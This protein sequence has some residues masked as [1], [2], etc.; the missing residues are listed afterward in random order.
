MP[1]LKKSVR[2]IALLL[3]LAVALSFSATA[4]EL[5]TFP[6]GVGHWAE[7]YLRRAVAE[8]LLAGDERGMLAPDD[9]ATM[10]QTLTILC[11]LLWP[12]AQVAPEDEGVPAGKWY[13]GYAAAARAM[14]IDFGNDELESTGFP[15]AR[16][17]NILAQAFRLIP[18]EPDYTVLDVFSDAGTL[19]DEDRPAAAALVAAG[20][21][22]GSDGRLEPYS[23]VSRAELVTMILRIAEATLDAPAETLPGAAVLL[24]AKG[25]SGKTLNKTVWLACGAGETDLRGVKAGT[26][27]VLSR[28]AAVLTDYNTDIDRLVLAGGAGDSLTLEGGHVGTLVIAPGAP[29]SVTVR[30]ADRVELTADGR[31]VTAVSAKALVISGKGNTVTATGGANAALTLTDRA[32]NNRV[33]AQAYLSRLELDGVRNTVNLTGGCA[34]ATV[35]GRACALNGGTTIWDL[36]VTSRSA[37]I[38]VPGTPRE[39]YPAGAQGLYVELDVP[40]TFDAAAVLP[41]TLNVTGFEKASCTLNWTVDGVSAG[42]ART[43]RVKDGENSFTFYLPLELFPGMSEYRRV[44]VVL[45]YPDGTT[46]TRNGNVRLT[47]I[48]SLLSDA[49]IALQ[50]VDHNGWDRVVASATV[51]NPVSVTCL[52]S[53]YVDGRL[54]ESRNVQIGPAPVTLSIDRELGFRPNAATGRLELRLTLNGAAASAGTT[55]KLEGVTAAY[56]LSVVTHD[57]AGDYTLEWALAHD[58]DEGVKT[59]WINAKDYASDTQYIIWVNRTYQRVNVFEGSQGSWRLIKTFLCGTGRAGHATPVSVS[60]VR[61]RLPGGW[62]HPTYSVRPVV[63]FLTGGYAFHSRLWNRNHTALT[64]PSIGYPISKGCVRMYDEDI[65]WIFDTIP[66]G[67]TVV[68]H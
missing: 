55:A 26:V 13:A 22:N 38:G 35:G 58:Y 18:A 40:E 6:D 63:Y 64:D 1:A 37:R 11:R 42:A 16:A 67:T 56:A 48:D 12:D 34:G 47:G 30:N 17:F 24:S 68:V 5:E 41:V 29:K 31:T 20:F 49:S 15:R 39:E 59:A 23:S 28:D 21:V 44:G 3:V 7:P 14:D 53:W 45:T 2:S 19:A 8:G 60:K 33:A 51:T 66:E 61:H 62:V 10:A 32:E 4:L 36:T 9:P 52:A 57:Y 50:A 25:L 43:I 54:L 65:Q 46:E 27:V